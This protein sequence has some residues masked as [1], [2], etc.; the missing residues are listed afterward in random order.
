MALFFKEVTTPNKIVDAIQRFNLVPN[1]LNIVMPENN[2]RSVLLW[3]N[4]TIEAL[5][6][7]LSNS[8][9]VSIVSLNCKIICL[10]VIYNPRRI[11]LYS[12]LLL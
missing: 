6:N 10:N 4:S 8:Q 1:K 9:M 3:I 5:K 2:E 7:R 11:H 12:T